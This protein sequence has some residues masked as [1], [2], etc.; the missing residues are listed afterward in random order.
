MYVLE[1]CVSVPALILVCG[2]CVL[3]VIHVYSHVY[4]VLMAYN[5]STADLSCLQLI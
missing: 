1:E 3:H 4:I 2:M 5:W